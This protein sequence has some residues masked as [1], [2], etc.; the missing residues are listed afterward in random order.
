MHLA[1]FIPSLAGGGA[2]RV[3]TT[4]AN[5][6]V[7]RGHQVD[8]LLTSKDGPFLSCLDSQIS[9]VSLECDHTTQT[10]PS[11]IGVLRKR[12]PDVVVT[13]LLSATVAAYAALSWL[14]FWGNGTPALCTIVHSLLRQKAKRADGVRTQ[15]LM[16]IGRPVLREVDFLI[17]VSKT[18]KDNLSFYI[19]RDP[20]TITVIPN[21]FDIDEIQKKA[22]TRGSY[23]W[24]AQD[25][26]VVVAVGR[27][28]P[29]KNYPLLL[30]ALS[31][32]DDTRDVRTY[33][34]GA[35]AQR[36][37]LEDLSGDLGIDTKVSFLGFVDDPYAIMNRADLLV[38][39]STAEAFG[40]VVIEALACGTPVIAME[41][42]GGPEELL[43][44][45][46]AGYPQL[47]PPDPLSLADVIDATLNSTPD[48]SRLLGRARDFDVSTITD[49]YISVFE[50][51]GTNPGK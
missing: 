8:L 40:N 13:S 44:E 45:L 3:V 21:P 48:V 1:F 25:S 28:C 23:E 18:V 42:S 39:P 38:L 46:D 31:H 2:E 34:L 30:H 9:L 10:V 14:R 37:V 12:T 50:R 7:Q 15:L 29:V 36:G 6:L 49:R 22:Q 17:A 4:L 24:I 11:L 51:A 43:E 19:D 32:L 33:I 47:A 16:H 41:S 5:A 26:P 27:L 35:G 20:E